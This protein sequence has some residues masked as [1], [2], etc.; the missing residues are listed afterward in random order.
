M[1]IALYWGYLLSFFP[2]FNRHRRL[3]FWLFT[4]SFFIAASSILFYTS[5]Y[6]F[7]FER[8]IFIYS[9]SLSLKTNV[10]TVSITIDNELIPENNLGILN[11]SI[12][13]AGLNPGEHFVEVT[14]PGYRTW[15]KKFVIQSGL[16]TEFWNIYLTE[17]NY[18]RVTIPQTENALRMF[19]S[20]DGLFAIIKKND[21]RS[22]VDILDIEGQENKEVFATTEAFFSPTLET[23]IEW[24]PE[25]HKLIIPLIQNDQPTY[26]IVTVETGEQF[27]LGQA[28]QVTDTI[29]SPR[30][31]ATTRDFLFFLSGQGLYR[32][33]TRSTTE[34]AKRI[35]DNVAAYDLSGNKL[36]YLKSDNGQVYKINGNGND[37]SPTEI[38]EVPLLINPESAYSLITYDDTRLSL[39]EEKNGKLF[40]YN[41]K[42]GNPLKEI[43]TGVKS[44]QYSD[45]GKK[46]LFYTGNEIAVYFNQDWE[47]QPFR[48]L[49]S[50]I[51]VARFSNPIEN[52]EWAEDYEHV[53]F[54]LGKN[55]KMIELDNRDRRDFIDLLTLESR[56]LQLLPRF[57]SDTLYIVSE[58]SSPDLLSNAVFSIT[59][60]QYATLFGR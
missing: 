53:I 56:P 51:Q 15:S 30:W 10:E 24:S 32:Y 43:H 17:E 33:D 54:T 12:Q 41:K 8:G 19:P 16:T 5:G 45:D 48:S 20:P 26:T 27:S 18:E 14:A 52:V 36:Y 9:G 42:A 4:A 40:V 22:S 49:D 57:G 13:V 29:R 47:A 31:D 58:T 59:L 39:I 25:S 35:M 1:L 44:I 55:I 6:R 11:N 34:P 38:T 46:L 3:I 2:M 23:N 28:A 37:N 21:T 60:P 7:S 50:I